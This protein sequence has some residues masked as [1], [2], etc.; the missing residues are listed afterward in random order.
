MRPWS[1][2]LQGDAEAGHMGEAVSG[3]DGEARTKI[4]FGG[5]GIRK[6]LETRCFFGA[7]KRWAP[8]FLPSF[9][10]CG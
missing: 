2:H 4:F 10:E 5:G 1:R 9:T 7:M 6:Q 8:H 3:G